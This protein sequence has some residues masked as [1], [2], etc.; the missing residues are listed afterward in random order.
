MATFRPWKL[1][2][3]ETL[4]WIF[5]LLAVPSLAATSHPVW[6]QE[7]SDLARIQA[8]ITKRQGYLDDFISGGPEVRAG[9]KSQ[10]VL[11]VLSEEAIEAAAKQQKI[12]ASDAEVVSFLV[13]LLA[14]QGLIDPA[15]AIDLKADANVRLWLQAQHLT[16]ED[17]M[18]SGRTLALWS[19]LAVVDVKVTP[20]EIAAYVERNPQTRLLPARVK[21]TL[22]KYL[23]P[24][25]VATRGLSNFESLTPRMSVSL[26]RSTSDSRKAVPPSWN[27]LS[28]Y[29]NLEES[30]PNLREAL[31]GQ[32]PGDKFGPLRLRNGALVE[33]QLD[34]L[35]PNADLSH[36]PEFWQLAAIR[37]R[38]EKSK[39]AETY[40]KIVEA[41]LKT[42]SPAVRNIFGD[43]WRWAKNNLGT[44][45]TVAGA[46]IGL[47]I[48]G[49]A[50]ALQGSQIGSQ[51]GNTLQ[52]WVN[53]KP[54]TVQSL[55]TAAANI[56]VPLPASFSLPSLPQLPPVPVQQ[57][58]RFLQGVSPS[59]QSPYSVPLPANVPWA[60]SYSAPGWGGESLP[61]VPPPIPGYG[62]YFSARVYAY[63]SLPPPPPMFAPPMFAP[64]GPF[65]F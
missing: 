12:T 21:V 64:F 11:D 56:G 55:V 39:Q 43:A 48:G 31:T 33:G 37:A 40:D 22:T 29:L 20:E 59:I 3:I 51:V 10:A 49:P 7:S 30:D 47:L 57:V 24:A 61:A 1:R 44:V 27:K 32:H 46:G 2:R 50:G 42:Q 34:G 28:L 60:P 9:T 14:K 62:N 13:P 63:P 36:S 45:G 25:H 6:A 23:A 18:R 15:S 38:L 35:V 58:T 17:L 4:A 65:A 53:G 8:A 5:S 54:P 19:K 16:L 26:T 52:G 41:Y